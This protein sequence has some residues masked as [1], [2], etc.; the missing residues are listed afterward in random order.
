VI[1]EKA[2]V[3]GPHEMGLAG[4]PLRGC[5]QKT[6]NGFSGD[7]AQ[8]ASGFSRVDAQRASTRNN[9]QEIQNT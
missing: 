7:I 5:S 3:H 4:K 9:S 1:L 6:R 8:W 2:F